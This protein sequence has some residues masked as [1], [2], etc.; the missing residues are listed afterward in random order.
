MPRL[1]RRL[2]RLKTKN[3]IPASA[4]DDYREAFLREFKKALGEKI[5]EERHG[6]SLKILGP[7]CSSC[8]RLEQA[9]MAALS[10]LGLPAAVEH[11]R[12]V[13]EITAMGV[14][15]VPALLINDEVK[16]VGT[17]PTIAMLKHWLMAVSHQK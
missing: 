14:F 7:G 16:A 9:A 4:H 8:D 15:G 5:E 13:R 6:L 3:Y 10:E 11:V 12:D 1:P 17:V 2:A